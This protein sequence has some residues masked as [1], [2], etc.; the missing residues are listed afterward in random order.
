MRDAS[1]MQLLR[2]YARSNSESAFAE[3]VRRHVNLVYSAALRHTGIAAQAEEITQ[4]VFVI[5]ARKAASLRE[6]LV[7]DA[8]LFETTRLTTLSF[9]RGERR[10]QFREQEAYMQSVLQE[11]TPDPVWPQLAPLLDDAVM[12]LGRPERE[13]VL[14]RFFKGK[15]L[16]E[17]AVALNI[18]EPAAQKRVSRALEKLRKYFAKRGVDSTTTAIAE[19]ISAHSVQVAPVALAKIVTAVALAKGAA[20][21]ASTLT[22]IQGALKIMAW[23]QMKSAI[24]AGT[25]LLLAA[26]TATVLVEKHMSARRYVEARA[27]WS[28]LGASTPQAALQ[29]LAWA[30]THGQTKRADQLMLWEETNT[31]YGN[32]SFEHQVV[33]QAIL[34]PAVTQMESFKILSVTAAGSDEATVKLQKTFKQTRIVPMTMTA[35]LR[36]VGNEWRVIGRIEYSQDGGVSTW[37]PFSV[38]F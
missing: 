38:S 8:W 1:D 4:A 19:N 24:V 21:S 27:P 5:L 29:S 23:T 17:V 35:K 10:R 28:D 31:N 2:E 34:A 3:L 13:A 36:R 12:R 22:L 9:L 11:S 37:L 14:L 18:N 16:G 26:T 7:L 30:L 25:A 32:P 6:G 33:L 20:A 15:S